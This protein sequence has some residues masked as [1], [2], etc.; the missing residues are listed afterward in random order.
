MLHS[1]ASIYNVGHQAVAELMTVPLYVEE[2]IDGSQI[3]FGRYSGELRMRSKGQEFPIDAA[4]MFQ[5]AADVVRTLPLIDGWTYRGEYLMK[6]KHNTLFY[7]RIPK[8][9]VMLFDIERTDGSLLTP[10]EREY[11]ADRLGFECVPLLHAG[12]VSVTQLEEF[13]TQD[14]VLGNVKR[15]GVV[16]KQ[17]PVH[18]G[19]LLYGRDQK[20][21]MAKLVRPDFKELNKHEFKQQNPKAGDIVDQLGERYR[22]NAR[23]NKSIQHL[24]D[25]EQL[26]NT[27]ADIGK[28]LKEIA[29]DIKRECEDDI[30]ERL[31]AYAWP[32]LSRLVT[33]GFP[34]YYKQKLMDDLIATEGE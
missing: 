22:T 5:K 21:L 20:V 24:R 25:N 9:Y 8:Q 2:K 19:G 30:K 16:L 7:G 34:E 3:S 12:T 31:F 18:S 29:T 13:L 26:T 6:P 32:H 23:W 14:S 10:E 27:P 11:E 1:Y 15:E 33:R 28:L 17:M 4:G